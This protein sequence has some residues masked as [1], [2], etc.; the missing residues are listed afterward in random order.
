MN[1]TNIITQIKNNCPS[2]QQVEGAVK[3]MQAME[4]PPFGVSAYVVPV[5]EQAGQNQVLNGISQRIEA[6]FGVLVMIVYDL[7]DESGAKAYTDI[8]AIREELMTAL[9]GFI[10]F[11][12]A[13]P[14]EYTNGSLSNIMP[15]IL[16]WNDEFS[17]AYYRFR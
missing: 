14:I 1:I 2:I 6:S 16:M 9:L 13:D 17:T 8:Q 5:G 4:Q 10:P 15:G 7:D 11:D 3:L 12:N